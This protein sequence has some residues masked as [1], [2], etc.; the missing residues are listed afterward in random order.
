MMTL[1]KIL[2]QIKARLMAS[3]SASEVTG[4]SIDSLS[5]SRRGGDRRRLKV[6][7]ATPIVAPAFR[8]ATSTVLSVSYV[9]STYASQYD[10]DVVSTAVDQGF[11]DE[12]LTAVLD[13]HVAC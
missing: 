9:T 12:L 6:H 11:G 8:W 4:H 2:N 10:R 13:G 3:N 7:L 5:Q 1:P